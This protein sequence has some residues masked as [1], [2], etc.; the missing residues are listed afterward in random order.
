MHFLP[1][2]ARELQVAARKR[3]TFWLR[4]AAALAALVVG[5]VFFSVST[6]R[7]MRVPDMGSALFQVLTWMCLVAGL[8][9][10][11]FFTSDSLSEE[12]REGTLGLLFLTPLRGYDVVTGKLLATSL[13]SFYALLALL[14]ILAITQLMGGVTGMQYLKS[15]LALLNALFISLAAGIFISAI[16]RD[17]Q[18]ALSATLLLLLVLAF[19]GVVA[20]A[21][22]AHVQ[23]H[24]FEPAWALSSPGYVLAAAGAWGRT[25]YWESLVA[26]H[27]AGWALLWAACGL[28]RHTWQEKKRDTG[29]SCGWAYAWRHGG[30]RRRMRLRRGLLERQP[31]AWLGCR[32]RWQSLNM[33]VLA[34]AITLSFFVLLV[35]KLPREAWLVWAYAGGLFSLL[36]YVWTASQSCRLLLDTR[37]SGL[38]ELLLVAPISARQIVGGQLRALGRLFGIPLLLLL[39][40]TVAGSTLSQMAYQ[41]V[42]TRGAASTTGSTNQVTGSTTTVTVVGP[43]AKSTSFTGTV[44]S[45]SRAQQVGAATGAALAAALSTAGNLLAI[46]WFGM[47][48][49]VTSKNANMAILKTIAFAQVIPGLVTGIAASMIAG[50]LMA[51]LIA[52]RASQPGAWFT[53]WPLVS[54]SLGAL[55]S[56]AKDVGFI[57][58]SRRKLLGSL[59]ETVSRDYGQ[60]RSSI[61]APAR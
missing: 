36:V 10:G 41:S 51:P 16:C 37:R 20:D 54:T 23:N 31:I 4:L 32:D 13:R 26:T 61:I 1:I 47:W 57:V 42:F 22:I 2:A 34:L 18:K 17:S 43:A 45:P 15:A 46:C 28:V 52:T 48:M 21:I 56:L 60:P 58:W 59:R 55:L 7:G 39:S 27:I 25:A 44:P 50:L 53:W 30:L 29:S 12:K 24:G 33:W 9:A 5:M 49:G 11:L 38:L 19:G 14:P 3:S 6:L 8:S 35:R 40:V